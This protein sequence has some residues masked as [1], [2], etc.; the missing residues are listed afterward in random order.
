MSTKL[1]CGTV[2]G[3]VC[4]TAMMVGVPRGARAA[5]VENIF[6]QGTTDQLGSVSFPAISGT[7]AAGVGLS[8]TSPPFSTADI[9]SASWTL[10]PSSFDV[11]ALSLD[12]LRGDNPCPDGIPCSNSTLQLSPDLADS[13]ETTCA[14][15]RCGIS[16][17]LDE[18]EFRPAAAPVPEPASLA[19]LATALFGLT[20]LYRRR[21]PR[22]G[23]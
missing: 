16:R 8:F 15:D 6:V 5:I 23:A 12:A 17:R 7:S 1:S 20:S 18:I 9:T 11:L 4:L 14:D 2:V 13:E 21:S 19:L 3:L 22:A 10:D